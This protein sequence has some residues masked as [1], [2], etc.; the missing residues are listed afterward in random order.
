MFSYFNTCSPLCD[1][2][3]DR[4]TDDGTHRRL[5]DR[6]VV[7]RFETHRSHWPDDRRLANAELCL[8]QWRQPFVMQLQRQTVRD[9]ASDF[10]HVRFTAVLDQ[11]IR[12]EDR[13]RYFFHGRNRTVYVVTA[14]EWR[15]RLTCPKRRRRDNCVHDAVGFERSGRQTSP[16]R[17]WTT[18]S[19]GNGLVVIAN[20]RW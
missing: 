15:S 5:A 3:T 7:K 19:S 6:I 13:R 2:R 4:R 18:A 16:K 1:R 9:V 17:R 20:E 10:Q 11:A 14:T 8:C 12:R